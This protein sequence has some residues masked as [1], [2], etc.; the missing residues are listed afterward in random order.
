MVASFAGE[1]NGILGIDPVS[2]GSVSAPGSG[3]GI[4]RRPS[5]SS[6]SQR[7]DACGEM[8]LSSGAATFE[9]NW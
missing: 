1:S 2:F 3:A 6:G 5:A 8:S 9:F 7:R 4:A